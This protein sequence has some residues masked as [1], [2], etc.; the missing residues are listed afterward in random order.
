MLFRSD[1]THAL[2]AEAGGYVLMARR[3]G[4]EWFV[5]GMTNGQARTLT[6]DLSFLGKGRYTL[7]SWS[8]GTNAERNGSDYRKE[9]RSVT[10]ADRVELK[11]ASGGGYVARIRRR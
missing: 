8:D 4:A 11:L 10:R 5:G 6:L 9:T 7:D 1:E 2:A 3:R